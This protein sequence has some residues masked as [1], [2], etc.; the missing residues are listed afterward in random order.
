ME[1]SA[2]RRFQ[3]LI[4]VGL[5]AFALVLLPAIVT[6]APG[7]MPL[8]LSTPRCFW[9][10]PCTPTPEPSQPTAT[11]TVTV[12]PSATATAT[13]PLSQQSFLA[14]EF[15]VPTGIPNTDLNSLYPAPTPWDNDPIEA[16]SP[17]SISIN[18]IATPNFPT[19]TLSIPATSTVIS[20][21]GLTIPISLTVTPAPYTSAI[22][23]GTE[24]NVFSG[25]VYTLHSY[26]EGIY[27]YT[28]TISGNIA[29]L[30]GSQTITVITAPAWYAPALPRPFADVGWTFEQAIGPDDTVPNFTTS[31]WASFVGYIISLPFSFIRMIWQ[32]FSRFGPF[33][34]FL[35]WLIIMAMFVFTM[36]AII[37]FIRLFSVMV[38]FIVRLAELLG[39]WVPTGG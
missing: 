17:I 39:E 27:S 18:P 6:A 3:N 2:G 29:A 21:S 5:V 32:L 25:T 12:D 9:E 4:A 35:S 14:P 34:L 22:I 7:E 19:I 16:P 15:G 23:S 37:F 33:G 26:S 36:E 24:N 20:I 38:R 11:A 8:P 10:N 13:P 1:N 28:T 30:Q 31:S